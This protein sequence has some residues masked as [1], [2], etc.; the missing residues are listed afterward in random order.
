ML[1]KTM[2]FLERKP[3]LLTLLLALLWCGA[4]AFLHTLT[5]SDE[6]RVC[7]ISLE[8]L[9]ENELL[10]PRL[11]GTPFVEYPPLFYHLEG[12]AFRLFGYGEKVTPV[13]P[14][15]I[16][17]LTVL[18]LYRLARKLDFS[19]MQA[20][21]AAFLLMSCGNFFANRAEVRVDGLLTLTVLIAL[22]ASV[23]MLHAETPRG[24][25]VSGLGVC[26]GLAAGAYTKGLIG[27]AL[28]LA[29]TGTVVFV[30]DVVRKKISWRDYAVL[31]A[32]AALASALYGFYFYL[33]YRRYGY[34][35]FHEA[36]IVNNFGRFTGSQG[37]HVSPF[38][39]YIARL[40]ELF[41][42]YILFVLAGLFFQTKRLVRDGRDLSRD[43]LFLVVAVAVPFLVFSATASKRMVYLLPLA[44]PS[45]LLA[46][47]GLFSLIG[48][49]P[50]RFRDAASARH[51][52]RPGDALL[53]LL[54]ATILANVVAGIAV[55]IQAKKSSVAALYEECRKLERD[56]FDIR[57][58]G[59]PEE[60]S[61]GAAYF[62]LHRRIPAVPMKEC[63]PAAREVWIVRDKNLN[64]GQ[65][66]AD[67]HRLLTTKEEKSAFLKRK[68]R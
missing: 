2:K 50:Q 35:L 44:P 37:D 20:S 52:K 15:L 25:I 51:A 57:F 36:C 29:V 14:A 49:L 40:P 66:F 38:Y 45:A 7:G 9:L 28:P 26:A 4:G 55:G 27:I 62:Y 58:P 41:P 21:V 1:H 23:S 48:C 65:P 31:V 56:G 59:T 53:L 34:D 22:S 10:L 30:G 33:L 46:A 13:V 17:F 67:H 61:A 42:P 11:N 68:K 64:V 3:F 18:L 43:T 32:A 63:D 54:A 5:S 8:M 19:A 39:G 47:Q 60:R 6:T 24:K 16:S 12:A